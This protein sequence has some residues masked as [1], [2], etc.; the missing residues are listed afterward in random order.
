MTYKFES[1]KLVENQEIIHKKKLVC[2]FTGIR[3][4]GTLNEREFAVLI[5]MPEKVLRDK[6]FD[7]GSFALEQF[8]SVAEAKEKEPEAVNN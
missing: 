3:A 1:Y 4:V 5:P 8:N 6:S 2:M 7:F